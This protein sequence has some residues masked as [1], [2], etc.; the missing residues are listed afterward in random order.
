MRQKN[1]EKKHLFLVINLFIATMTDVQCWRKF[2]PFR[3]DGLHGL[4]NRKKR[5]ESVM[6]KLHQN[7]FYTLTI[8]LLLAAISFPICQA[9]RKISVSLTDGPQQI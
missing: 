5:A 9:G 7:S 4:G 1:K 6:N 8:E 2:I 3:I